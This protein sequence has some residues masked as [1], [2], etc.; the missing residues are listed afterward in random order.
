MKPNFKEQKLENFDEKLIDTW[1]HIRDMYSNTEFRNCLEVFSANN[2]LVRWL[3][4]T[5]TGK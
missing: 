4:E 3:R 5:T 1:I 2:K